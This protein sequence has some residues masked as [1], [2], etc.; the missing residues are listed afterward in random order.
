M[1]PGI[2]TTRT[3]VLFILGGC[4]DSLKEN[5]FYFFSMKMNALIGETSENTD[6]QNEEN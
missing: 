4:S 1:P 3:V 6:K 5:S 2:K